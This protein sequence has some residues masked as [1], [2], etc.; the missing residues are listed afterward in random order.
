L[1]DCTL[2]PEAAKDLVDSLAV[3]KRETAAEAIEREEDGMDE[4]DEFITKISITADGAIT[5]ADGRDDLSDLSDSLNLNV[6]GR[7][8][9][10]WRIFFEE[11]SRSQAC[12][13]W[14]VSSADMAVLPDI[15]MLWRVEYGT[16]GISR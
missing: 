13:A 4:C 7:R 14:L 1:A 5:D 12:N 2:S 9:A 6:E 3:A 10:P 15:S 16:V 8:P 11:T